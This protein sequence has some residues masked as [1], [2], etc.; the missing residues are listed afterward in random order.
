[1]ETYFLGQGKVA[2]VERNADGSTGKVLYVG[3]VPSLKLSLKTDKI[4]HYESTSGL[5][6]QDRSIIK[7]LG[8]EVS[9]TFE[10]ITKEN[11][12]VLLYGDTRT[13]ASATAQTETLPTGIIAGETYLLKGQNLTNVTVHDSAGT[14]A[15]V[16]ASNYEINATF[17]TIKFISVGSFTQ[18]FT[19]Q[20]DRGAVKAVPMFSNQGKER[21]LRFEGINKA[22]DVD[23]N[24]LIE[25]YRLKFDPVKDFDIINEDLAK[26]ELSG[27]ALVDNTRA[28][29]ANLGKFGRIV[30]L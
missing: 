9:V 22:N 1:M 27:S 30:Y 24:V 6:Q 26:F 11:A 25:V 15:L 3:N 28:A 16:A 12:E 10:E 20:S 14:P 4:E 23:S 8:A 7:T 19:V 13:I 5:R 29:D 21:Y 2:L 17:G 18:P